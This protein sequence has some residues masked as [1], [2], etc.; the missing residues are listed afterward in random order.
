MKYGKDL[1]FHLIFRIDFLQFVSDPPTKSPDMLN[2]LSRQS[3]KENELESHL[4]ID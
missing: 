3:L 2:D 1:F 4:G